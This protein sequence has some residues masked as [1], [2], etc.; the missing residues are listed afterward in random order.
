VFADV[1]VQLTPTGSND[2]KIVIFVYGPVSVERNESHEVHWGED[3]PVVT[4]LV[5]EAV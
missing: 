1:P 3:S 4:E 5:K 2:P